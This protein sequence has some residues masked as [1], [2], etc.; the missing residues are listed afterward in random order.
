MKI[1]VSGPKSYLA[2]QLATISFEIIHANKATC[3]N[4]SYLKFMSSK[5]NLRWGNN[6]KQNYRHLKIIKL[7]S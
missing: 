6:P 2:L 3:S 5:H 1:K 4:F 7:Y